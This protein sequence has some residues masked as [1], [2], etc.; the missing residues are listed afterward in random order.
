GLNIPR[1]A[2]VTAAYIQ[3]EADKSDS[4]ASSLTLK[5]ELSVN[6]A[7]FTTTANNITN[8]PL[9]SAGVTW[10]PP[11]W[12][13]GDRGAAQKTPDLKALVQTVV[14]QAA[15]NSGNAIVFIITGAGT[16]TAEAFESGAAKA[17][18]LRVEWR[19][20]RGRP[21]FSAPTPRR[22]CTTLPLPSPS[23]PSRPSP[24]P[25]SRESKI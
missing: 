20:R 10:S 14:N 15:W 12:T 4:G 7:A 16:R 13:Q 5:A 24:P 8:R 19:W 22:R 1:N 11:A 23:P 6:A 21:H 3:F 2:T 25:P 17:P 9:T 18:Q